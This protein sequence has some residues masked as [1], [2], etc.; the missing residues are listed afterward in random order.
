MGI[1]GCVGQCLVVVVVG[2]IKTNPKVTN[3]NSLPT[4]PR[5]IA[6][7]TKLILVRLK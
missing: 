1:G 4:V 5:A 2:T 7:R 6:P 3:E